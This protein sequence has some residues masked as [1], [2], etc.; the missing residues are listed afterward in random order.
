MKLDKLQLSDVVT[1]AAA[2]NDKGLATNKIIEKEALLVL[3]C[4]TRSK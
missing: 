1:K 4:L 2:C 3:T